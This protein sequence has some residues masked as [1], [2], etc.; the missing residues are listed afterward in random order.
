MKIFGVFQERSPNSGV[1]GPLNGKNGRNPQFFHRGHVSKP[2]TAGKK[3][4]SS[5]PTNSTPKEFEI[6]PV[7]LEFLDFH[8][9]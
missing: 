1:V 4:A 8:L 5:F 7:L 2:K 6:D 9:K 3:L